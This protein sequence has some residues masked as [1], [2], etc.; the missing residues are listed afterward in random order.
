MKQT[1][2]DRAY[3][4]FSQGYLPLSKEIKDLGLYPSNRYKYFYEWEAAGKPPGLEQR[5]RAGTKSSAGDSIGRIDETKA[6]PKPKA[7]PEPKAEEKTPEGIESEDEDIEPGEAH[8]EKPKEKAE[9]IGVVSEG[10]EEKGKGKGEAEHQEKKIATRV[11]DDGIKCS[12]FLS[13]QTLALYKIAASTQAQHDGEEGL[14]LGDFLDTCA[15]DFFRV[16]GRKLGLISTG[17]K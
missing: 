11:A 4:L 6:K 13:L 3:A 14:N 5:Q 12:V 1:K 9:A 7:E 2:K 16:R 15:E 17:G 8:P 10:T